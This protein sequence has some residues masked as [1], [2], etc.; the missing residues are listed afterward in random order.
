MIAGGCVLMLE[1]HMKTALFVLALVATPALAHAQILHVGCDV[2]GPNVTVPVPPGYQFY[3][4]AYSNGS[5]YG[6]L[7]CEKFVADFTGVGG[8]ALQLYG[9]PAEVVSFNDCRQAQFD[10]QAWGWWPE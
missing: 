1:G 8:V 2:G 4:H 6:D 10:I 9:T 3:T 5:D 7:F